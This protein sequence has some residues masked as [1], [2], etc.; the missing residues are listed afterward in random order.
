M[1]RADYIKIEKYMLSCMK[2]SA[3]DKE[4]VYRVLNVALQIAEAEGDIDMDVLIAACLLHDIGR[5]EQYANPALCHAKVGAEKSYRFLTDNGFSVRFSKQVSECINSHRFRGDNEPQSN[6]AKI[7]FDAD[8]IDATG[9]LGIARTLFW[10]GMFGEPLYSFDETGAVSDGTGDDKASFFQE[11]KYKL[12]NIYDKLYT[13]SGKRIG[14]ERRQSAV[15]FY[16]S[17][18]S[19]VKDSYCEGERILKKWIK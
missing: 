16:E 4:H 15:S 2:D 12:E 8:K 1:N 19:E 13:N 7:L 17:M 10:N 6:E 3:H 18:L 14:E 5:P 11:Y 9:T